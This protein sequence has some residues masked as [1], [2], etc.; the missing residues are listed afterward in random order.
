MI[1]A[2]AHQYDSRSYETKDN[3]RNKLILSYLIFGEGLQ[4]NHHAFPQKANFAI[5]FPEFDPGYCLCL[6]GREIKILKF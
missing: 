1:N 4:N 2:L 6:I 5:K 3:S